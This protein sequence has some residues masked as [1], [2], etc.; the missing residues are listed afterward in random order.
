MPIPNGQFAR[1][2]AFDQAIDVQFR[3][4]TDLAPLAHT[5]EPMAG[6]VPDTL[7]ALQAVAAAAFPGVDSLA[8]AS[9]LV[10]GEGNPAADL[11]FVGEA[12]GAEEDRTGRPFVGAAGQKLDEIITAMG[13]ARSDVYICNVLKARPPQNRTPLPDE[14]A[15]HLPFLQ[16]QLAII[17]P[18]VIVALGGPAAKVLLN[19][20]TGIT[21]L[22][23]RW[24]C[25]QGPDGLQIPVMPTFH[26][27]YLLRQYT[28]EV[29]GQVWSDMQA[30]MARVGL[31]PPTA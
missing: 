12:P 8:D 29:R 22:R 25:W 1:L 10:F 15:A 20:S 31:A 16:Q 11:V 5:S 18:A 2:R 24:G 14:V 4:S 23:G 6:A 13:L 21:Q 30:V 3:P 17:R 26:P 7:E 9:Q 28:P 19:T 27:A